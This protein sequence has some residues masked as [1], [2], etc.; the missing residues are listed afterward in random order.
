MKSVVITGAGSGI[1]RACA[2]RLAADGYRVT[3]NDLRAEAAEA[4]TAEIKATGGTA[5]AAVGRRLQRGGCREYRRRIARRVWRP[6]PSRKQCRDR[7]AGLVRRPDA[8]RFRPDVRGACARRLPDDQGRP[9]GDAREQVRRRRQH[10]LAARTDWRRRARSLQRRES[11]NHRPHEVA[12]P[13][14]QRTW[15][16]RQRCRAWA[17]QHSARARAVRGLA[18]GKGQG[19][20]RSDGS[21]SPRRSPP[22]SRFFARTK[23]ASSSVRPSVRIPET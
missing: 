23:R 2:L 18:E 4:V 6:H 11:G 3:V 19:A 12:R 14:G 8:R 20:C 7:S 15:R 5:I 22:Q 10:G 16:P 9:A 1:G 13:R 17:D 21:A